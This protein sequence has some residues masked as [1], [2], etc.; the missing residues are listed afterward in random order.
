MGKVSPTIILLVLDT[1][2]ADRMSVYGY[3]KDTTPGANP[4]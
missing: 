1:Q 4:P 3:D 2:R